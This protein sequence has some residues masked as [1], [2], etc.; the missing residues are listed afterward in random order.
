MVQASA[1]QA[2]L[3]AQPVTLEL[4]DGLRLHDRV[5][6]REVGQRGCL[7]RIFAASDAVFPV[8]QSHRA[9]F[10]DLVAADGNG[11]LATATRFRALTSIC[12]VGLLPIQQFF[13]A[14]RLLFFLFLIRGNKLSTLH[15]SLDQAIASIFLIHLRFLRGVLMP[16]LTLDR[17]RAQVGVLL[18]EPPDGR[19]FG[20]QNLLVFELRLCL[21]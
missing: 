18:L 17:G 16:M 8:H 3:S 19:L 11:S 20:F 21:V 2:S 4:L 12:L 14:L 6:L 1:S 13:S 5:N 15:R 7:L 10:T 9:V